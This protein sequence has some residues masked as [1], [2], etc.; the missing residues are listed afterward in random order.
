[1]STDSDMDGSRKLVCLYLLLSGL[2]MSSISHIKITYMYLTD[3]E[4]TFVFEDELKHSRQSFKEK[5]LVFRVFSQNPKLSP[6]STLKQ[7]LHIRL[8]QSSHTTLFLTTVT[9]YKGVSRDT[10]A[11]WI[12]NAVQETR[13]NTD[14]FSPIVEDRMPPINP[15]LVVPALQ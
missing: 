15:T 3:R 2:Y 9:P 11:R 14:L 5:P 8:L 13:I 4:C 7:Y 6:V 1:M 10:I 12:K